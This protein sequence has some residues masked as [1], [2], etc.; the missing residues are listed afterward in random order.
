M[1]EILEKFNRAINTAEPTPLQIV[2]LI[3]LAIGAMSL[4]LF[5]L[6]VGLYL[7]INYKAVGALLFMFVVGG[8]GVWLITLE[9]K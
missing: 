9:Q 7:I 2:G 3:L 8:L 5:L 1:K 6:M 4:T